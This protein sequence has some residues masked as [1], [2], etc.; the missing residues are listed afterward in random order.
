MANLPWN[1]FYAFFSHTPK[2]ILQDIWLIQKTAFLLKVWKVWSFKKLPENEAC[3]SISP[4]FSFS[5]VF[6]D[7]VSYEQANGPRA[8]NWET[9][10]PKLLPFPSS[11]SKAFKKE[12][13]FAKMLPINFCCHGFSVLNGFLKTIC[14][15]F[16][17]GIKFEMKRGERVRTPL[18]FGSN[19]VRT[20][21]P[22]TLRGWERCCNTTEISRSEKRNVLSINSNV[23][24]NAKISKIP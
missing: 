10:F 12:N 13:K 6:R 16:V 14:A 11:M 4:I 17:L 22:L 19:F 20:F 7:A 15:L 18:I 8:T 1:M 9:N 24:S 23:S 21:P 3:P 2:L 5:L